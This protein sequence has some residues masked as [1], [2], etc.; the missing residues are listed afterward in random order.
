MSVIPLPTEWGTKR[1]IEQSSCN[2]DV[3]CV[4]GFCPSFVTVEGGRLRRPAIAAPGGDSLPEPVLPPLDEPYGILVA[5]VGGTGV[6]TIAAILGEAASG[7]GLGVTAL[8]MAGLAQKGGAVWSHVRLAAHPERLYAARIAAGEAALVLGCDI[9]VTDS[10]ESIAKMQAGLTRAVVNTGFSITSDMVRTQ[11][12]QAATG[13]LVAHPDPVFPL[14]AMRARI[15]EAVGADAAHFL[16]ASEL[17]TALLGDA[18]ATNL[19]LVGFAWQKGLIPLRRESIERAIETNGAA[20]ELNKAAFAWGRR[21]AVDLADVEATARSLHAPPDWHLPSHGLDALIARRVAE[22]TAYQD[23]A[24][25]ARYTALVDRVRDAEA[26]A[27]PG[28]DALTEAVARFY[29]KLLAVKD[30]YEVARL[31]ADGAFERRIAEM[32]EGEVRLHF[33][34]APPLLARRDPVTG[35]PRKLRLGPWFLPV[36]RGLA[37]LKRLRGTGFDPFGWT[38]ERRLERQLAAEYAATIERLLPRLGPANHATAVAIARLPDAIRGYGHVKRRYLEQARRRER[39]L[40]ER[41]A[42]LTAPA[43]SSPGAPV[44]A[45]PAE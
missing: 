19:L 22:L 17:A 35:V 10:D 24:Y 32:F 18:I 4:E 21:A 44:L 33:H 42:A 3:S 40:L 14:A 34:L 16:D 20:V 36:L 6:V 39:E 11:A 15:V 12:A 27:V 23:E 26:R 7:E 2:K 41:F 25:A 30:E 13:D 8:D 38:A 28:A 31:Y 29:F 9:V 43:A 5:G 1:Q 45:E 37:R